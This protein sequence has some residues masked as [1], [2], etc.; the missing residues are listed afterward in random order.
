MKNALSLL[1][2][3]RAIW[4]LTVLLAILSFLPVYSAGTQIHFSESSSVISTLLFKH[5]FLLIAGFGLIGLTHC[6]HIERI[7]M[8][9]WLLLIPSLLLLAYT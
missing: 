6:L 7:A 1:R 3:D 4:A 8:I 2:G 9:A 5:M